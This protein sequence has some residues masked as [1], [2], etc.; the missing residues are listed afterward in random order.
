MYYKPDAPPCSEIQN[1]QPLDCPQDSARI[2]LESNLGPG[3]EDGIFN[4]DVHLCVGD[5]FCMLTG[6]MYPAYAQPINYN[7][8]FARANPLETHREYWADMFMNWVYDHPFA[9]GHRP[10][11]NEGRQ[12][13]FW[14]ALPSERDAVLARR[15]WMNRKMRK[16]LNS[17]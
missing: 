9:W 4:E 7:I 12:A 10:G 6:Y 5:T 15:E 16:I 1:Q 11:D 17:G 3:E 13:G 2:L 8:G 14:H